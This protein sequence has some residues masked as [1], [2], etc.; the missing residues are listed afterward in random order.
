MDTTAPQK[1]K[2]G[3]IDTTL[4]TGGQRINWR[5]GEATIRTA[6]ELLLKS[7]MEIVECGMLCS[8]SAG[9]DC[10]IYE[11]T[12]LPE[13]IEHNNNQSYSLQLDTYSR[14][15]LT[16]IPN[17][18]QSTV[19]IIRLFFTSENVYEDIEYSCGLT[20][21]GYDVTV[22]LDESI[23]LESATLESRL[24]IINTIHPR[25]CVLCDRSGLMNEAQMTKTVSVMLRQLDNDIAI[26]FQ[27]HNS[28]QSLPRLVENFLSMEMTHELFL[29]VGVGGLSNGSPQI[30][31][32]TICKMMNCKY[33]REYMITAV[34]YLEDILKS[35]IQNMNSPE[36][37]FKYMSAAQ[38]QCSYAYADYFSRIGISAAGQSGIFPFIE[39]SFAHSFDKKAANQALMNYMQ[40][41]TKLA[42]VTITRNRALQVKRIL[43]HSAEGAMRYGV[44][45]I[46]LDDSNDERTADCVRGFQINKLPNIYYRRVPDEISGKDMQ[47]LSMAYRIGLDYDYIWVLCDD[48]IPTIDEFYYELLNMLHSRAE[49]V[50]VDAL[51]RNNHHRKRIEY[52]DCVEFFSENSSRLAIYSQYIIRASLVREILDC[53]ST[54]AITHRFWFM[55]STMRVLSARM[56]TTGLLISHTFF[57][58]DKSFVNSF[59][60]GNAIQTWAHDWHDSVM[61]L[62][63]VF[64][65]TKCD[66]IRF[67]TTD[68]QPFHIHA[69]L[70][71][72]I[73]GTFT[74][75][76]YEVNKDRILAVSNTPNWKFLFVALLPK[77]IATKLYR[78]LQKNNQQIDNSI[79]K[80]F[81][82]LK[83]LYIRLGG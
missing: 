63:E 49:L 53:C 78:F 64:T 54:T 76:R 17:R 70:G 12:Y 14:P 74:L 42:I 8:Y 81:G 71:Q 30:D 79:H 52:K 80:S 20:V 61:A 75:D 40:S 60:C 15:L 9:L 31:A 35:H 37:F 43:A 6:L 55:E 65:L 18:D 25:C 62:P 83:K 57:C 10:A 32:E 38:V 66:A 11:S 58:Y 1:G 2:I 39:H 7:N 51:Y 3:I 73:N 68:M 4:S 69:L 28:L 34:Y 47:I 26:G 22:M 13:G 82:K 36:N 59:E 29:D 46:I 23:W 48:L 45:W 5:F 50:I 27:G 24:E 41:R 72:R 16:S 56:R 21:K 19:D 44:D 33:G 67:H 77:G